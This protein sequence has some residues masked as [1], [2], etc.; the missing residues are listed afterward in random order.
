MM[1]AAAL[2]NTVEFSR[3]ALAREAGRDSPRERERKGEAGGGGKQ[4]VQPGHCH[5]GRTL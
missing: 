5:T 3:E 2:Q 4:T 1:R